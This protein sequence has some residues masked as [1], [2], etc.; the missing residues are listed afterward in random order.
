MGE[1]VAPVVYPDEAKETTDQRLVRSPPCA[2]DLQD[3]FNHDSEMRLSGL[4]RR[5]DKRFVLDIELEIIGIA[6]Y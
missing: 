5:G 4:P 6:K 3:K 1:S 2:S